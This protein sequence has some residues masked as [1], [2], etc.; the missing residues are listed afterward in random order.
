MIARRFVARVEPCR[1]RHRYLLSLPP[2]PHGRTAEALAALSGCRV[3]S[4]S[5]LRRASGFRRSSASSRSDAV[6]AW[7]R[8]VRLWRASDSSSPEQRHCL[9]GR[10]GRELRVRHRAQ[11]ALQPRAIEWDE[12]ADPSRFSRGG[13]GRTGPQPAGVADPPA[14]GKCLFTVQLCGK[15][16]FKNKILQV[17]TVASICADL[18]CEPHSLQLG[19]A[20]TIFLTTLYPASH[21]RQLEPKCRVG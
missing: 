7:R 19:V 20:G 9:L 16:S 3:I 21:T 5:L 10:E 8:H 12:R 2:V 13:L 1:L 14:F 11:I 4:C 6:G 15:N 18:K 17:R